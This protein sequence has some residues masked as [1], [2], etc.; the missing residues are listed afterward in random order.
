[1][2]GV[3]PGGYAAEFV[4][5]PECPVFEPSWEEFSDPLSFIGRIR[6][7]AEKTGIC[8]IRPP[9]AMTRVRLDFLDQL[10][11]FWELQGSTL[12][13][14][15]VERKILDLYALS[16]IVASKGGFEIVT[17]EKKWSKVGSRLGYLPGKGTGSLLKSHYERILYP[18]ELFQSGVSLM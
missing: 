9:K 11:K 18:Y 2:A 13:I 5:P 16:K 17:K 4:P 15:V 7:L 10:A 1:M 8:K 3:G 12:K 14:P 6:P